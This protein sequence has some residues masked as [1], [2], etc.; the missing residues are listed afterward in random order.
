MKVKLLPEVLS[1]SPKTDS[2]DAFPSSYERQHANRTLSWIQENY[3]RNERELHRQT[4]WNSS[5]AFFA[6]LLSS[7][8]YS[9]E[10]QSAAL[11]FF[12][13]Q[14]IPYL[15]PTGRMTTIHPWKSFMTDDGTPIE[16]S[17]D[18][19]T[20]SSLPKIRYSIEPCDYTGHSGN[21]SNALAV[22]SF[23]NVVAAN[24]PGADF[25]WFDHFAT[26]IAGPRTLDNEMDSPPNSIF[27]A[28]D[29][30]DRN[31]VAKAYYIL[32]SEKEVT[33]SVNWA[34]IARTIYS[35]P[36]CSRNNLPAMDALEA[37]FH[38]DSDHFDIEMLAFDLL[39][40][41][42]SRVK[43]YFRSRR[44]SF[45]SIEQAM[46]LNRRLKDKSTIKGL[47]ALRALWN[48]IFGVKN[49]EELPLV[50]HRTAGILYY[51]ELKLGNP[52]PSVKLY[53][54]VRHY[55][56]SDHAVVASLGR[57]LCNN[58]AQEKFACYTQVLKHAL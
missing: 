2:E 9:A 46:T 57:Y 44:T 12:L 34:V 5:G 33:G 4:W 8:S 25:T 29:C 10:A 58:G 22:R 38:Q 31:M 50:V 14:V 11:A 54:P 52:V 15:G 41:Q 19:T 48:E 35:A 37:F 36:G 30:I 47:Q 7:A 6:Q 28:F 27:Y 39:K 55:A 51:V 13:N 53:I 32:R 42:N 1:N 45:S 20:R 23:R 43:I 56:A 21:S 16:F 24:I 49:D 3:H 26:L 40:P 17:W 18:W